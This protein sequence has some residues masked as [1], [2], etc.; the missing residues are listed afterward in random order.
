MNTNKGRYHFFG[1][2]IGIAT[3][4]I[5]TIVCTAIFAWLIHSEMIGERSVGYCVIATL[6]CSSFAGVCVTVKKAKHNNLVVCI[7]SGMGYY[8]AMF[9][10]TAL[11]YN[12]RFTGI[13]QTGLLVL[14]G[15]FCVF[16]CGFRGNRKGSGHKKI[17]YSG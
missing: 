1:A 2:L 8:A 7:I 10:I 3:A 15:S 13:V 17:R 4:L 16:L 9:I 12:G 6:L 14:A 5:V 11:F